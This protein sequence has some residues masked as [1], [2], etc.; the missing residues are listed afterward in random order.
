MRHPV[1][2]QVGTNFYEVFYKMPGETG[3]SQKFRDEYGTGFFVRHRDRSFI[4]TAKHVVGGTNTAGT[5]CLIDT[6][7]S[8]SAVELETMREHSVGARWFLHPKADVAL[9]PYWRPPDLDI[10][11]TDLREE[12]LRTNAVELLSPVCAVGF[13]LLLGV[14]HK[15][16]PILTQCQVASWLT[17]MPSESADVSFILLDKPLAQGYSGAPIFTMHPDPGGVMRFQGP[18]SSSELIGIYRGQLRDEGGGKVS[19]IVPAKYILEIF[20]SPEF[21]EYEARAAGK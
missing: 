14:G 13:P 4:V 8:L 3:F 16:S 1:T 17:A 19:I 9:H 18:E 21:R 15:I 5:V 7:S 11:N 20:Q 10:A 12:I 6:N 2:E